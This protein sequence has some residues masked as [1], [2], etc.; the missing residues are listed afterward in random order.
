MKYAN[1]IQAILKAS[2]TDTADSIDLL[3]QAPGNE[4]FSD[5][6]GN[7]PETSLPDR[8]RL[9]LVDDVRRPTKFEIISFLR[10][11]TKFGGHR[12]LD[13][14]RG[15]EGTTASAW[16][17]ATVITNDLFAANLA[18]LGLADNDK[19]LTFVSGG[20]LALRQVSADEIRGATPGNPILLEGVS[21]A[22]TVPATGMMNLQLKLKGGG[23]QALTAIFDNSTQDEIATK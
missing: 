18:P 8:Q 11:S 20:G 1:F 22:S 16:P 19:A 5:N 6:P 23:A 9:L 7:L 2:I 3:P 13:V 4:L 12:L 21:G 10:V 14:E 17:A 15:L